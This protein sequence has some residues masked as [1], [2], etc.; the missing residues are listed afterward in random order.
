MG[1]RSRIALVAAF[2]VAVL[3]AGRAEARQAPVLAQPSVNGSNV[4]FT[5]SPTAGATGYRL[6]YGFA[7][8]AYIGGLPVGA[9]TTFPIS[10]PNGVFFIRVVAL[11]GSGDIASNEITLQVPAP[12]STPTNLNVARNGLGIVVSWQ[13]GTSGGT[14][15]GYTLLVNAPGYGAVSLPVASTVFSIGPV[16]VGDY[17][18]QVVAN[19]AAGA[20][21]PSAVVNMN[22]PSGGACDAPPAPGVTQ[23]IF[24]GYVTL[25]WTPIGG[26]ASYLLSGFQNSVL[27][28]SAAVGGTT[29]RFSITL[30]QA[31]WRIDVA[32]V[33]S[34]GAQGQAGSANFVIDQSTLKMQPRE[35]DPAPGT[36]L[37]APPYVRSV[38]EDIAARYP[39]DL[40]N[41]CVEHGGNNR[42]LFRLVNALRERDKRWGLNWKRGV[43]GDPSQDVITYNFSDEPDEGTRRIR[44][45]D[46]I[47]GHCG[48]NPGPNWAEIT[49]PAPPAPG[50]GV[51][52]LLPYIQAG[53]TP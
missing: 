48:P 13:P 5:W 29:T 2:A 8:G 39:S 1:L 6:D 49:S 41:S 51:W 35:P 32:A 18:F 38:I 7:S 28:G 24:G 33:F 19:N 53:W 23:S 36:A 47:G 52:T 26:A 42:W 17:T 43:I 11:T 45:W 27:I 15:T 31:T 21:A 4:T 30:P 14:P 3:A 9:V 50:G 44:A 25:N 12:P 37:P 16:P 34:C 20:S 22:M 46:V 40:R 10:A